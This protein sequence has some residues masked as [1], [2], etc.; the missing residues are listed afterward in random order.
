MLDILVILLGVTL[1]YLSVTG[2]IEAYIKTLAV[3]GLLLFFIVILST[4]ELNLKN[5]LFVAIE[6]IVLKTILVPG[7]MLRTVREHEIVRE[8]EPNIPNFTSLLI[9]SVIITFGFLIAFFATEIEGFFKPLHFGIAVSAVLT[10]LFLIL[11]RKKLITHIM[12]YMVI[13]NGAFLL[14]LAAAREMP[15][16]VTLG[17]SLDIFLSVLLAAVVIRKITSTFEDQHIDDLT[18]LKD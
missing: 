2:M 6:T 12:G 4:S 17:V 9:V 16:I 13:E 7:I 8:V 5:F 11:T 1:L 15:V 3:Q 10:G 18:N 14:S